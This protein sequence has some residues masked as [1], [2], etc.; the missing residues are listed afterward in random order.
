M[1]A[2]RSIALA[3]LLLAA[4][5]TAFA[6][7]PR[8]IPPAQQSPR[9]EG[10]RTPTQRI[11]IEIDGIY[12]AAT[13]TLADSANPTVYAE[14]ASLKANYEVP[15]GPGFSGGATF[16]L[17]KNLGIGASVSSFSTKFPATVTGSIPQPFQF[18]R[19]RT[20]EGSVDDMVRK[21]LALGVNLRGIF[22]LSPKFAF[23]V[24]AGPTRIKITQDVITA[25]RY[26]EEYP[27][28]T[29]TFSA[30][31][32][33]TDE[34]SKVVFGG[35]ADLAFYFTK[36]IGI[37]AGIKY[38]GGDTLLISLSGVALTSKV[39]GVEYGGGLRLRF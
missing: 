8:T 31:Q 34:L 7:Q 15:A 30:A 2:T 26:T 19:P 9:Q 10:P 39:G 5:T 20:F 21:E 32:V 3:G 33:S 11:H 16:R 23:S 29:A 1:I 14:T 35:G 28:D 13:Q 25:I 27:Y 38:N 36:S 6:Q 4:G 22:Q 17:W 12:H 24:F 37:G 18:N